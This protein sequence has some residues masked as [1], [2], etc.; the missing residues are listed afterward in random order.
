MARW[1]HYHG[2]C[3]TAL[4]Q[5]IITRHYHKTSIVNGR[6]M[7]RGYRVSIIPADHINGY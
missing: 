6:D 3:R 5:D 4:S 1:T 2:H 7:S